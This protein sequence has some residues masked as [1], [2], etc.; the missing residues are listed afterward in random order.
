VRRKIITTAVLVTL[1]LVSMIV[2]TVLADPDNKVAF[3]ISGYATKAPI[4]ETHVV[5]DGSI[6]V[7]RSQ[8]DAIMSLK[9]TIDSKIYYVKAFVSNNLEFNINTLQGNALYKWTMEFYA[10]K[11]SVTV[12]NPVIGT[13]EGTTI[14]KLTARSPEGIVTGTGI[15]IGSHGTGIME[16]MKIKS[17]G[18]YYPLAL[19]GPLGT[20]VTQGVSYEGIATMND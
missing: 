5:G 3:T 14:A 10:K 11:L 16:G 7:V 19:S 9:F 18:T 4:S 12:D 6:L 2:P 15:Q 20:I 17:E 1:F 8:E 13:L